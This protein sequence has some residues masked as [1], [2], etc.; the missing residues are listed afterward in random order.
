[1]QLQVERYGK[2]NAFSFKY[3][4][5]VLNEQAEKYGV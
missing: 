3:A 1:M 5:K 2:P 4:E